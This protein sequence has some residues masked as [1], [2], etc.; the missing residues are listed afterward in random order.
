MILPANIEI[1]DVLCLRESEGVSIKFIYKDGL[2]IIAK[3][4]E[5]LN[6]LKFRGNTKSDKLPDGYVISDKDLVQRITDIS[7]A[8]MGKMNSPIEFKDLLANVG[9]MPPEV[10]E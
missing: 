9:L 4:D 10:E 5:E 8:I 3:W 7:N 1:P 2:A 6:R